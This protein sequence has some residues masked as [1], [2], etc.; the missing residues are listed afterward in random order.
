MRACSVEVNSNCGFQDHWAVAIP[1]AEALPSWPP[2]FRDGVP[3]AALV[4]GAIDVVAET[5]QTKQAQ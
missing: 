3:R 2:T 1:L 5:L 4:R